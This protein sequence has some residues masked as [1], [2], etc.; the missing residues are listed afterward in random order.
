MPAERPLRTIAV[1]TDFSSG[2]TA[3]FAWAL[4]LARAHDA[5]LLVQALLPS[6]SLAPELAPM[7]EHYYRGLRDEACARLEALMARLRPAGLSIAIELVLGTR[8]EILA[9]T[10]RREA[11]VLVVAT[12]GRA[13]SA[14]PA[15]WIRAL[16]GSTVARLAHEAQVPVLSVQASVPAPTRLVRTVLVPT[17][18]S[19]EADRAAA[20]ALRLIAPRSDVRVVLLHAAPASRDA[21][22]AR[23]ALGELAHRVRRRVAAL[24]PTRVTVEDD[25]RVGSPAQAVIEHAARIGADLIVMETRG[26]SALERLWI[27]STVGR[28]VAC[29]PCPVLTVR[30]SRDLP[31][32]WPASASCMTGTRHRG[33]GGAYPG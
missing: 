7:P 14:G 23:A 15:R 20:S 8:A 28:V 17:D 19:C 6:T 9:T 26:R 29:A 24:A 22:A 4:D 32:L 31:A 16:S 5:S 3:A 12:R 27:G 30:P 10:G 21:A 18:L 2:A 25:V 33:A 11:D 13:P 1:A